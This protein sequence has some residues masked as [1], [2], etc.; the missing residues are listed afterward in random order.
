MYGKVGRDFEW[1]TL[2]YPVARRIFSPE[3]EGLLL[4]PV[5]YSACAEVDAAKTTFFQVP[6]FPLALARTSELIEGAAVL[7]NVP[8]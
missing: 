6:R 2:V 4:H 8:F 1:P 3:L 7:A 5:L